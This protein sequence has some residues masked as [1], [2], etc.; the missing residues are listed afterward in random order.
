MFSVNRNNFILNLHAFYFLS[1][2]FFL[3]L[4]RTFST[5]SSRCGGSGHFCLVS[6]LGGKAVNLSPLSI[7][8]DVGVTRMK[9]VPSIPN[10][11][12]VFFFN[13]E[14]M[15]N[16]DKCFSALIDDDFFSISSANL[17]DYIGCLL[18]TQPVLHSHDK[19]HLVMVY[20]KF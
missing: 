4:A 13:H 19:A 14:C 18:N 2:I 12:R 20:I 10:L 7:M 1:L 6:G 11:L 15:L 17:V 5:M 16:F 3:A 8:L 9:K